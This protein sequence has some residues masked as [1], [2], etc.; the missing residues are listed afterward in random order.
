MC[1]NKIKI[2]LNGHLDTSS[3][4]KLEMKMEQWCLENCSGLYRINRSTYY[5]EKEQDITGFKL[6]FEGEVKV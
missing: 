4:T 6:A 1:K 2:R 3:N 5:F